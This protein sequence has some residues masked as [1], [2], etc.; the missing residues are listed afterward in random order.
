MYIFQ[1][2]YFY[3][4]S[5]LEYISFKTKPSYNLIDIETPVDNEF[6]MLNDSNQMTR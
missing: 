5:F 4:H 2:I 6:D 3:I 1:N